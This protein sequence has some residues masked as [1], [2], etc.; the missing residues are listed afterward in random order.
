MLGVDYLKF[1]FLWYRFIIRINFLSVLLR[2]K[3]KF[4][5]SGLYYDRRLWSFQIKSFKKIGILLSI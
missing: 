5:L 2:H 1:L 4:I 3:N